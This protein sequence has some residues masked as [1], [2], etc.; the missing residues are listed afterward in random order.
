MNPLGDSHK[1]QSLGRALFTGQLKPFKQVTHR[2]HLMALFEYRFLENDIQ[3]VMLLFAFN[4]TAF[5]YS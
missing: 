4:S 3:I 1:G 5:Y 2:I